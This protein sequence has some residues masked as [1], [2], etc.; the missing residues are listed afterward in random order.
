MSYSQLI[1]SRSELVPPVPP[2]GIWASP[3][4][5][6]NLRDII[7]FQSQISYFQYLSSPKIGLAGFFVFGTESE[8]S[9]LTRKERCDL[10]RCARDSVPSGFPIMAG[11]S[12]PSVRQVREHIIDAIAFGA[13]YVVVSPPVGSEPNKKGTK[14]E[15]ETVDAFFD[16]IVHYSELR[17]LISD[18]DGGIDLTSELII[19]QALRHKGKIVGAHLRSGNNVVGKIT[20]LAREF[21]P[22]QKEFAIFAGQ[23]DYLV[24]GLA[25]GSS[26]C[27]T[28]FAN[29]LPWALVWQYHEYV[30]GEKNNDKVKKADALRVSGMLAKVETQLLESGGGIAAIKFAASLYTGWRAGVVKGTRTT[31]RYPMATAG[32]K[33]MELFLPRKPQADI[34]MEMKDE[35]WTAVNWA[36]DLERDPLADYDLLEKE[37]AEGSRN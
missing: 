12:A 13:N 35:I 16:D 2:S 15:N 36:L 4:T 1:G 8:A 26:G 37:K 29:V 31:R 32:H 30:N 10:L 9:L 28:A 22:S 21:P 33:G 18:E 7:D 17:I 34:S 11:V 25:A 23:S 19:R 5:L 6:F 20:R 27:I 24:G 3:I 14:Q